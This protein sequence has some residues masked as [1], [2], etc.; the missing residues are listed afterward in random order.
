M[1]LHRQPEEYDRELELVTSIEPPSFFFFFFPSRFAKVLGG[2]VGMR[3]NEGVAAKDVP[4]AGD[5]PPPPFP[6]S[7]VRSNRSMGELARRARHEKLSTARSAAP[8]LLFFS[9]SHPLPKRLSRW[10]PVRAM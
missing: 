5:F 3:K 2:G 8:V 4:G 10:M 7:F 6:F 1:T 9:L